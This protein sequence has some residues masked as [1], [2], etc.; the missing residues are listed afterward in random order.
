LNIQ[1][2]EYIWGVYCNDTFGNSGRSV[3]RTFR[4]DALTP[5]SIVLNSP[6]DYSNSTSIDFNCSAT[7]IG[8]LVNLSLLMNSTGTWHENETFN[9]SG[10]SNSSAFIKNLSSNQTYVW[11]CKACDI[12]SNCNISINKTLVVDENAPELSLIEPENEKVFSSGTTSIVF[13]WSVQDNYD[14]SIDCTIYTKN[15]YQETKACEN[16][17]TCEQEI[18]GFSAGSYTWRVNCSDGANQISSLMRSFSIAQA[19]RGGGGGGGALP[20]TKNETNKT[21]ETEIIITSQHIIK[22]LGNIVTPTGISGMP[23]SGLGVGDEVDFKILDE[24]HSIKIKEI[25]ESFI[26]VEIGSESLIIRLDVGESKEFDLNDDGKN[27][28][29]ILLNKIFNG[30]ATLILFSLPSEKA[31]ISVIE[32]KESKLSWI[33]YLVIGIALV[34]VFILVTFVINRKKGR[35]GARR[36]VNKSSKNKK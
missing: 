18:S 29:K 1:D 8:G 36:N 9:I 10:N 31:G 22:N 6:S 34:I 15:A 35:K 23:I 14:S 27:D 20:P 28:F 25:G 13:N 5:P 19:E 12:Q 30:R 7:D 21:N 24:E 3:N 4:V 11:A 2:G 17:T 16:A 26:V 32:E 33:V